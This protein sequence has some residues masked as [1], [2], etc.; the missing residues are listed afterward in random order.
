MAGPAIRAF[1]MARALGVHHDVE[2]LTTNDARPVDGVAS[3]HVAAGELVRVAE[4]AEVVVVQGDAL[5]RAPGLRDVDAAVV[6]DLYDPF[7]LEILEQSRHLDAVTRRATVGTSLDIVNEQLRRGDFFLC[8]S[9]RQRDFWLGQLAA[10]GRVNERVYDADPALTSL[11]AIVPFGV[12][13]QPPRAGAPALRGVVPGIGPGDEIVYW[14]GGIYDWFDPLTPIRAIE[15]LRRRRERIRLFFA[16]ARHPN[17]DVGETPMAVRARALADDL[18]LTGHTVFFHDWIDYADRG[19]YLCE[20]DI[21]LSAHVEHVETAYAFRTRVLDYL[22]AGLPVVTTRGDTLADVV[23]REGVGITV[24]P[25]DVDALEMALERLLDEPDTRAASAAAARRVADRYRW[26]EVLAPLL[27]FCGRPAR[28]PDLVH[29]DTA[30][31]VAHGGDLIEP[32]RKARLPTPIR[33]TA[34]AARRVL[35]RSPPG[36][37]GR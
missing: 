21:G 16:G 24:P 2:L 13:D 10:V 5:R 29:D 22:W 12:E 4:R 19:R 3:R 18:H 6:V 11:L 17:P 8:A 28:S 26:S 36:S 14:G 34:R 20:A 31:A 7:H 30:R 37:R 9:A 1:Q 15:R 35:R 33:S 23:E 25:G 27:A 32:D